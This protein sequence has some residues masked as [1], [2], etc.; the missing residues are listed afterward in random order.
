M[1]DLDLFQT[2]FTQ[3][4]MASECKNEIHAI[5][6]VS[7]LGATAP[8]FNDDD[9]LLLLRAAIE[10]E[11]S[12]AAFAKCYGVDRVYLD[13]VLNGARSVGSTIAN[14]LGLRKAY[15]I[16]PM[17]PHTDSV[18][19]KSHPAPWSVAETTA[20]FVVRDGNGQTVTGVYFDVNPGQR[21]VVTLFTRDEAQHIAEAVRE[22]PERWCK[23]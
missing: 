18:K 7:G 5:A 22:L 15:I 19:S 6:L 11:G 13:M 9:V 21:S 3:P 8:V 16:E 20:C 12:Q 4:P 17:S 14:A 23:Q 1:T 2:N 10:R